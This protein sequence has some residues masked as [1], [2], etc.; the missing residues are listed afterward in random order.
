[1]SDSGKS[2][3]TGH[4]IYKLGGIDK[5]VIERFEKEAA[6]MNKSHSSTHGFL[7]SVRLNRFGL[8]RIDFLKSFKDMKK[9]KQVRLEE[10]DA[11]AAIAISVSE[12]TQ[13]ML[14]LD[15]FNKDRASLQQPLPAPPP[16][17]PLPM[18]APP[19]HRT[20]EMINEKLKKAED[21]GTSTR[22]E[23]LLLLLLGIEVLCNKPTSQRKNVATENLSQDAHSTSEIPSSAQVSQELQG[24]LPNNTSSNAPSADSISKSGSSNDSRKVSQ[25][26]QGV[27]VPIE[28]VLYIDVVGA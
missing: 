10:D 5:R 21:L 23:L 8:L 11:K 22:I 19:D 24:D 14:L 20:Q 4:L 16:L 2:T 26:L 1:M 3:T 28:G 9:P 25:E 18:L 13:A 27:V 7:T 15:A 6:E 17:A 12:V